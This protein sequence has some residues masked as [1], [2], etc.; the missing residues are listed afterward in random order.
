MELLLQVVLQD[1]SHVLI[2]V[3]H[4]QPGYDAVQD[5][6]IAPEEQG[7][8]NYSQPDVCKT[9]IN[10]IEKFPAESLNRQCQL[11]DELA[12]RIEVKEQAHQAMLALL[13]RQSIHDFYQQA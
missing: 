7:F 6:N 10:A 9:M 4:L 13:K 11:L 12:K 2:E 8:L 1:K 5:L 3:V